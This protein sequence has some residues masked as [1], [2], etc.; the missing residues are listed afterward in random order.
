MERSFFLIESRNNGV[1]P[2]NYLENILVEID[3]NITLVNLIIS[4][5]KTKTQKVNTFFK[6]S[7]SLTLRTLKN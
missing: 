2:I 4:Y 1:F 6:Y 7:P 3:I 5:L